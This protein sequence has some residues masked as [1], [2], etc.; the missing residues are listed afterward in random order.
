M[1][2]IV[3][4]IIVD[5][6]VYLRLGY[7]YTF[8]FKLWIQVQ[9]H[10]ELQDM[11]RIALQLIYQTCPD[12]VKA[13]DPIQPAQATS[14][15]RCCVQA[16]EHVRLASSFAPPCTSS[17]S[18]PCSSAAAMGGSPWGGK[19]SWGGKGRGGRGPYQ[20]RQ[21]SDDGGLMGFNNQFNDMMGSLASSGQMDPLGSALAP[22]QAKISGN[23]GSGNGP[24]S[25]TQPNTKKTHELASA[26]TT[27]LQGPSRTGPTSAGDRT[28]QQDGAGGDSRLQ[29][30]VRRL[31]EFVN[32]GG[33][34]GPT[35]ALEDQPAFT[36]LYAEMEALSKRTGSLE[37]SMSSVCKSTD[38]TN[39]DVKRLMAMMPREGNPGGKS[40]G[41]GIDQA[42]ANVDGCA[43][44][45]TMTTE[46]HT[47]ALGH[48]GV[49]PSRREVK[50][51]AEDLPMEFKTWWEAISP[52]K[53]TAQWRKKLEN[54]GAMEEQCKHANTE[55]VGNLLFRYLV[56][57]GTWS[58][59][60]M[61]DNPP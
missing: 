58:D 33:P 48:I 54:L 44:Q 37:E 25:P 12:L 50:A 55:A 52:L 36:R 34:A 24:T 45:K 43:L 29:N 42:G 1:H 26:L 20:P 19:G 7:P 28:P 53:G 5:I 14:Y 49:N 32:N 39:Q 9:P 23:G 10:T 41:G 35:V 40:D 59:T 56:D 2:I 13:Q 47:K 17:V 60:P 3:Y 18:T 51:L 15:S 8:V 31:T 57:D 61:Q 46:L 30:T 4:L 38:E 11:I 6:L 27:M 21:D 16:Q 22:A